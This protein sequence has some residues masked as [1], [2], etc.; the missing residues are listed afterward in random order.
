MKVRKE[1]RNKL[2]LMAASFNIPVRMMNSKGALLYLTPKISPGADP[3]Q[4]SS[5]LQNKFLTLFK[6]KKSLLDSPIVFT[7]KNN[8]DFAAFRCKETPDNFL[9]LGPIIKISTLKNFIPQMVEYYNIT[10]IEKFEELVA[11]RC[12]PCTNNRLKYILELLYFVEWGEFC[13]APFIKRLSEP[14]EQYGFDL[15]IMEY[16]FEKRENQMFSLEIDEVSTIIDLAVAG[17]SEAALRKLEK[18]FSQNHD[19]ERASL[20]MKLNLNRAK[21]VFCGAV[22]MAYKLYLD[23]GMDSVTAEALWQQYM[24]KVEE[25]KDFYNLELLYKSIILDFADRYSQEKRAHSPHVRKAIKY[26]NNNLHYDINVAVIAKEVNLNP[27]YLSDLFKKETGLALTDYVQG[28][29]IEEAMEALR[30][31]NKSIL[32]ISTYLNFSSQGYFSKIFKK[33][34]GMSPQQYR[35]EYKDSRSSYLSNFPTKQA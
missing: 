5:V 33:H 29:R 25:V 17:E 10:D 21:R 31:S 35:K 34:V 3:V 12:S 19:S 11:F 16:T 9:L 13:K 26:I 32:E 28:K 22:S 1:E 6:F 30:L 18:I 15:K 14:I 7:D 8:L 27:H 24:Q 4:T 23:R 2:D 20:E